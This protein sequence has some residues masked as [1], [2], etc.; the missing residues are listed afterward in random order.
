MDC[1][2]RRS[3]QYQPRDNRSAF[4]KILLSVLHTACV[5]T[6]R[7]LAGFFGG[8]GGKKGGGGL[9]HQ[10]IKTKTVS[11]DDFSFIQLVR[12][13]SEPTFSMIQMHYKTTPLLH[14]DSLFFFFLTS[15]KVVLDQRPYFEKNVHTSILLANFRTNTVKHRRVCR[16]VI[17]VYLT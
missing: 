2:G 7:F 12:T 8:A 6:S 5:P 1:Y 4:P 11:K 17:E 13:V 14:S 3:N 16:S 15:A 10:S 9:H